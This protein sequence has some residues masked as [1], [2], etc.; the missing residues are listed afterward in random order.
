MQR[1]TML[2]WHE[3]GNDMQQQSI[4]VLPHNFNGIIMYPG[5]ARTL[6]LFTS[7]LIDDD[8]GKFCFAHNNG[9]PRS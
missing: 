3:I 2:K 5:T 9:S 7:W 1:R 8:V 6:F 4:S